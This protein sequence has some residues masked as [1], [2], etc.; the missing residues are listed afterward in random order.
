[1]RPTGARVA[2]LYGMAVIASWSFVVSYAI[3]IVIQNTLGLR[4]T[5]APVIKCGPGPQ[6]AG[7]RSESG[8]RAR[9]ERE[10]SESGARAARGAKGCGSSCSHR[11]RSVRG[12][13]LGLTEQVAFQPPEWAES[14]I[15]AAHLSPIPISRFTAQRCPQ[16]IQYTLKR[17]LKW[18]FTHFHDID[19]YAVITNAIAYFRYQSM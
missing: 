8:A 2:Q 18:S 10:R 9:A 19:R 12:S 13:L 14:R 16:L 17:F 1:M 7:T 15:G 4:V 6:A 3:L 5:G 11:A